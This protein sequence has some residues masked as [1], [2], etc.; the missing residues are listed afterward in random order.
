MVRL[1]S[2]HYLRSAPTQVL[3]EQYQQG[4]QSLI[5]VNRH[6]CYTG[7]Y[8]SGDLRLLTGLSDPPV[9]D[10][11]HDFKKGAKGSIGC[12]CYCGWLWFD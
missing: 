9:G 1:R 7:C 11:K 2:C 8:T 4:R 6:I 12:C 10:D 3:L 5:S